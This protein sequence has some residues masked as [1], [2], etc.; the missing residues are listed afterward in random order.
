MNDTVFYQTLEH[1]CK[2][3]FEETIRL[4]AT[5]AISREP[6]PL[7]STQK[8]LLAQKILALSEEYIGLLFLK[9]YFNNDDATIESIL[10]STNIKGH[11]VFVEDIL[12][13]WRIC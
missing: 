3:S 13:N 8:N 9:Y 4:N 12:W 5:A 11:L 10:E 1:A 2:V 7:N 6:I